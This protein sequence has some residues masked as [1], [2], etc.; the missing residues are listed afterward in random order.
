MRHDKVEFT[1]CKHQW[2]VWDIVIDTY[3]E[4]YH[5]GCIVCGRIEAQS[6]S[7]PWHECF[8]SPTYKINRSRNQ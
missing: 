8:E 4:T 7:R 3:P 2:M 6:D 1:D 5:R